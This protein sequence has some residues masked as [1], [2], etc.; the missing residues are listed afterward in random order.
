MA[1]VERKNK[2]LIMQRVVAFGLQR[3]VVQ[4]VLSV[5]LR[6]YKKVEKNLEKPLTGFLVKNCDVW[7]FFNAPLGWGLGGA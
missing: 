4:R 6:C 7:S 5:T 3:K 1:K 2:S